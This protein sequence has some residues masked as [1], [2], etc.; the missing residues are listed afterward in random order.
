MEEKIEEGFMKAQE[1]RSNLPSQWI[2][3]Y[4]QI[5]IFL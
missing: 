1:I 4:C 5:A 2:P 3:F